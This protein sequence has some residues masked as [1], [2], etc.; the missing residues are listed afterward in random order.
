M[1]ND[2]YSQSGNWPVWT[3]SAPPMSSFATASRST[4]CSS[5]VRSHACGGSFTSG[6]WWWDKHG[7]DKGIVT[8]GS[9]EGGM[10]EA[11]WELFSNL[12]EGERTIDL[13][14]SGR[15]LQTKK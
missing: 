5:S 14:A 10:G 2:C 9:D 3:V 7:G 11:G 15:Q 12:L 6:D 13:V 8:V 1:D 4:S